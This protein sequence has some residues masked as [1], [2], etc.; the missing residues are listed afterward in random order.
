MLPQKNAT[1]FVHQ[2]GVVVRDNIP[3]SIPLWYKPAKPEGVTYVTEGSKDDLWNRLIAHFTL[4]VLDTREN[5][6]KLAKKVKQF[7]LKKMAEQFNKYKNQLY[8]QYEKDN[9]APNFTGTLQGQKAHWPAFVD[10]KKSEAAKERSAKNKENAAKKIYHH[11]MGPG[12]YRTAEPKWEQVEATMVLKGIIPKTRHWPR[13]VRNF[14]L[15]QIGRA[16]V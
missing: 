11:N 5:T 2:C 3:I 10:Y 12:G 9:K 15:G 7:T 13:R 6:E 1:K 16:H 8:R 4:P 14:A